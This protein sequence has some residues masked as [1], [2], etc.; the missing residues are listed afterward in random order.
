MLHI[1]EVRRCL[2]NKL[3]FKQF[4]RDKSGVKTVELVGESFDASENALFGEPSHEYIRREI[5]WYYSMSRSVNAIEGNT[6]AIWKYVSDD[7]GYINSNYGWCVFSNKYNQYDCVPPGE[8][9]HNQY[10]EVLRALD[11]NPDTRQAIMIYTR[12]TMHKDAVEDGR[13]D[14]MC[15]NTVQYLIRD[16]ALDCIVNMRSNDAIFGYRN[17]W[18]WQEHIQRRLAE[19][20]NVGVGRIIWQVGSLHVYERHFGLIETWLKEQEDKFLKVMDHNIYGD[21]H[22][23]SG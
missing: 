17:D 4:V 20:L 11:A 1:N 22:S 13:K 2:A 23:E 7:N 12:P 10:A 9:N 6:P 3:F 21:P 5:S 18:A 8:H 19:Q 15:T 16:G 14:F